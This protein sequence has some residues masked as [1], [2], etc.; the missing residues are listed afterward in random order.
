MFFRL[1]CLASWLAFLSCLAF[2]CLPPKKN[3][4]SLLS[5]FLRPTPR[6]FFVFLARFIF[7]SDEL[8]ES[9]LDDDDPDDDELDE[10]ELFD[11]DD[12]LDEDFD[13]FFFFCGAALFLGGAFFFGFFSLELDELVPELELELEDEDYF[14]LPFFWVF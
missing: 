14:L 7:S 4:P 9:E 2:S 11:E 6:T 13:F 8:D 5:L 10:P 1:F 12:E 3:S